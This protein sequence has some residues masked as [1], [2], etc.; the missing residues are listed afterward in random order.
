[1]KPKEKKQRITKT[2]KKRR[3]RHLI[4]KDNCSRGAGDN[5][6]VYG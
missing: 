5:I 2:K 4:G 6:Y 3:W 1:M